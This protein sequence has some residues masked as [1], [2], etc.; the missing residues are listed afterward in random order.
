MPSTASPSEDRPCQGEQR[1]ASDRG[2]RRREPL[3]EAGRADRR[4]RLRARDLRLLPAARDPDAARE[5]QQR[6]V[7][8]EPLRRPAR[9]GLRHADHRQRRDSRVPVLPGDH[10]LA[11]ALHVQRGR[12][13]PREHARPRG[14]E[15]QGAGARF[16]APARGLSRAAERA[17]QARRD[18][19]RDHRDA[20]RLRRERSHRE[21]RA[22]HPHRSAQADRRGDARGERVL[23]RLHRALEASFAVPRAR[24]PDAREEDAAAELPARTRPRLEHQRRSEARRVPGDRARDQG[25]PRRDADPHDAAALDAAGDLHRHQQRPLR[26]C[27]R[28]LHALHEPDPP[29]PRSARAPRDQGVCWAASAITL[30][31]ARATRRRAIARRPSR[32]ARPP[33]KKRSGKSPAFIAASTSAAPTK[34]R[35][36]SR[37]G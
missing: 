19:F 31:P 22:A 5:A 25:P 27:V 35:A 10:L 11:C 26:A 24:R 37:P 28:G 34:P 15:A 30:S 17:Q 9:D 12:R 29:L 13:D 21:D 20:D 18:R 8:A 2:D 3:R 23:G 7:L 33:P 32:P 16:A 4:R 1:L 36:M 6:P 14:R